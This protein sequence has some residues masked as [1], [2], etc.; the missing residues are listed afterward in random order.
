[1]KCLALFATLVFVAAAQAAPLKIFTDRPQDRFQTA[2]DGMT[3]A[4]GQQVQVTAGTA[5]ELMAKIQAGE[6]ADI[7]LL[8]DSTTIGAAAA[9]GLFAPMGT[10]LESVEPSMRDPQNRWT[11]L[12]YR[13]RTIFIDPA[14]VAA[15]SVNTYEALSTNAFSGLLCMRN[16]KEYMPTLTAWLI[17][18]YGE[19][20]TQSMLEGFK[21][22][23]ATGF[24]GGD[25]ASLDA[26]EAGQCVATL[27]NHYY[28]ARKKAADERFPVEIKFVEQNEGGLHTNGFGGGLV[29]GS[30]NAKQVDQF[31]AYM[32][33]PLGQTQLVEAPG[34]EYPSVTG[35][36]PS[37]LVEQLGSFKVSD[38]HWNDVAAQITKANEI[39]ERVGWAK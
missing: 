37:S 39:L 16:A 13:I 2:L 7:L 10:S 32:L 29:K 22:N 23:L 38:V 15:D 27:S 12:A 17:V 36:K 33:S 21:A 25:T 3:K 24:T 14:Q 11:A 1:M 19:A 30:K 18:R 35:L 31:F 34:Y 9:L 28:F 20:K 26:I 8:K 5:N 4:T 6:P